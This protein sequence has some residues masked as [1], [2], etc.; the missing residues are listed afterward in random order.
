MSKSVQRRSRHKMW[1]ELKK[2]L[3][4]IIKYETE[5]VLLDRVAVR[6][7]GPSS[8]S[9]RYD[10]S[11]NSQR[12]EVCRDVLI[13]MEELDGSSHKGAAEAKKFYEDIKTLEDE[14]CPKE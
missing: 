9:Y 8:R 1:S 4:A 6:E 7:L 11:E 3:K 2:Y 14:L 5:N 12:A 10:Y 13:K